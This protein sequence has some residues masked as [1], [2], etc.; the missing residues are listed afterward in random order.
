[1]IDITKIFCDHYITQLLLDNNMKLYEDEDFLTLTKN[2]K[3]IAIFSGIRMDTATLTK[4]IENITEA[5]L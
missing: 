3:P 4:A 5:G 1:M 2:G